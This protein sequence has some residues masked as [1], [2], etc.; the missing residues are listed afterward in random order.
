LFAEIN[1]TCFSTV[2]PVRKKYNYASS[3]NTG[4]W[5]ISYEHEKNPLYSEGTGCPERLWSLL[6]RYQYPP[7]CF[8][9]L[10]FV[11]NLF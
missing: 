9:V 7:G 10:S 5:G 6:W 1:I 2:L 4:T 8:C 11:G 3:Q